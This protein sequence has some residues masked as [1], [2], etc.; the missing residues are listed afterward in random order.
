MNSGDLFLHFLYKNFNKIGEKF[1]QLLKKKEKK[2]K[3]E[4]MNE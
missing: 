2:E 3:K 4:R 1:F